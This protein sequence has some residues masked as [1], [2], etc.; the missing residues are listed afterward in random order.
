MSN[1][2][3]TLILELG[4]DSK[5]FE[6]QAA[7]TEKRLEQVE[8]SLEKS[9]KATA[10]NEK[11]LKKHGEQQKKATSQ[12]EKLQKGF[13][14]VVKGAAAL[15]SVLLASSGLAKLAADAAKANQELDNLAKNM[16]TSRRELAVWQGAA[17]MAGGSASGMANVMQN[18]TN[19]MNTLIMQGTSSMLPYF[20]ELGVAMHDSAGKARN[21][22][23]VMLELA[24][25]FSKRDRSQAH[26]L[27]QQMGI[28]DD[29][30]NTLVR[31]R[32]E[33]ER[34][35][36]VQK[37]MYHANEQDIENSRKF[38]ET[39]ALLS[40][41][42]DNLLLMIGNALLPVLI[43]VA[44][45]ATD[46]MDFI[47]RHE[48]HVKNVFWG[49]AGAIG[50][51]LMPMFAKGLVSLL[52]FI[53]PF[54]PFI[55][56]VAAL[57]AAF[58]LLY[59][60]YK[61][62]AEG[63]K[64]LFDWGAFNNYIMTGKISTDSLKA[65]F[66]YL[67]TGYK[68][69]ATAGNSLFDWLKMK[70]FIDETGFSV[71]SL[72]N[73][74]RN[75][76]KDL[77]DYIAPAMQDVV[78]LF[79]ALAN[80]DF[81]AAGEVATRLGKRVLNGSISLY[82]A[83]SSRATGAIDTMLGHDPNDPNS[84]QSGHRKAVSFLRE[85][86]GLPDRQKGDMV[87][88][89]AIGN[90]KY[91]ITSDY[92]WRGSPYDKKKRQFHSGVDY[93]TP[94]GTEIRAP[95]AGTISS[96]WHHNGGNQIFLVSEDGKRRWSF[97][98][99]QGT[100]LAN[101]TKIVAGQ[102]IGKTGNSGFLDAAGK[103][104]MPVHLHAGLKEKNAE[105][106]WE[107]V[108]IEKNALWRGNGTSQLPSVSNASSKPSSGSLKS[109]KLFRNKYFTDE[110]AQIIAETAQRLGMNPNDLAAVISFETSGTFSPSKRNPSSSATGLIQFMRGKDGTYYGM[111]RDQFGNLSFA[112]QM[113]Y[114]ERYFKDRQF[115]ANKKVGVADVYSAVTGWGYK[116]GSKEY[117]LNKVWDSNKN[118]VI[119]KGE[120]VQNGKFREHQRDYFANT[121]LISAQ[122]PIG[123]TAVS[124]SLNRHLPQMSALQSPKNVNNHTEVV[125]QNV[126][127]QT[128]ASTMTGTGADMMKGIAQHANQFNTGLM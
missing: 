126:S 27:A 40:Q 54:T 87:S 82:D 88:L 124:G 50:L 45:I 78:S 6:T 32:A 56:T 34:L 3:D 30:F 43:E 102:V 80:G 86:A 70:G 118:G 31:G 60:D 17:N 83:I 121:P 108:D 33:M 81:Q 51:V 18:L 22:N 21:V 55:A 20:N 123:G 35:L 26:T 73:G 105:G 85:Q 63:G 15:T 52:A 8:K 53:A 93:A 114:V 58:G 106:K 24:D 109:G 103:K 29:T 49:I 122:S 67:L 110:K 107:S 97:A 115:S 47:I 92:G 74:F 104:P 116:K 12:L 112:E 23:D 99:T 98:H 46:F 28:D 90:G 95:E 71:Q 111:S 117:E 2:I 65:A 25:S 68:D 37:S 59:D 127:V 89:P 119:E 39:R 42:W 66:A 84:L 76:A 9:E 62:W 7:Q 64:S 57:A 96:N 38:N 11:Q 48:N 4:I 100:Q 14:S 10:K 125:V 79:Q 5:Q 128:S 72:I 101:G 19:E 113:K 61:T 44:E 13:A 69:W 75:L 36:A 120:M 94:M 16:N 41:Q 77:I 1:V 91:K